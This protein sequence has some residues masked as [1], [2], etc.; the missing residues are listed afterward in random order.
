MGRIARTMK[1][2]VPPRV[3]RFP[4]AKQ[5]RLDLLLEKNSEGKITPGERAALEKLVAEAEQLIV[6]NAKRLV[7]FS[8]SEASRPPAGAVPVTVWVKPEPAE[9]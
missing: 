8:G 3:K 1:K 6:A 7:D 2:T 5:R 9:R 4:A